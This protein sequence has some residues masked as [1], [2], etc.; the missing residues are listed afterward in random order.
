M[1]RLNKL[2]VHWDKANHLRKRSKFL[3]ACT[4]SGRTFEINSRLA[5]IWA[6]ILIQGRD[7]QHEQT[8]YSESNFSIR[9]NQ[10]SMYKF[11][12]VWAQAID[13]TAGWK[14]CEG[15]AV[16]SKQLQHWRHRLRSGTGWKLMFVEIQ[17]STNQLLLNG[18]K[19][20]DIRNKHSNWRQ[21][22]DQRKS[23][24]KATI[25]LV[26]GTRSDKF[27]LDG[28]NAT[29]IGVARHSRTIQ[30]KAFGWTK[31]STKCVLCYVA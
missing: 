19:V 18:I 10:L 17:C 31:I 22:F 3:A 9:D 4:S 11:D 25:K 5:S 24:F 23:L 8:I 13:K 20:V 12:L 29:G 6:I 21:I 2:A 26:A 14:G 30:V 15:N 28:N 16:P 27:T 7:I 1:G